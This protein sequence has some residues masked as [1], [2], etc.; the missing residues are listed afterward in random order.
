MAADI[1]FRLVADDS[2]ASNPHT[3]TPAILYRGMSVYEEYSELYCKNEGDAA[4]VN[5]SHGLVKITGT[6]ALAYPSYSNR[7]VSDS[8]GTPYSGLDWSTGADGKGTDWGYI[9][10]QTLFYPTLIESSM[11]IGTIY[12]L[13]TR[14]IIAPLETEQVVDIKHVIGG[15]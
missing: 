15:S 12:Y 5:A 13:H 8:G 7:K 3:L 6:A 9:A 1:K 14:H 4:L 2:L 10:N 11:S